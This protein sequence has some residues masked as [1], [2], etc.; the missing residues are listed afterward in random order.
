[1]TAIGDTAQLEKKDGT[2]IK[3]KR[4]KLSD[5]DWTWITNKGWNDPQ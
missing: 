1:M 5:E 3:I 2:I 4:D